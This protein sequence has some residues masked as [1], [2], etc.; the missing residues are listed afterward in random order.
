MTQ[1]DNA[2][3]GKHG[4]DRSNRAHVNLTCE[5]RQDGSTWKMVRLEDL[6]QRGFRIAWYPNCRQQMP[7]KVR[8]PGLEV[9]SAHIRWQAGNSIGCEFDSPL[10]I[11]IFEHI[12]KCA[13]QD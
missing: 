2:T 11:A 8:I 12:A 3:H 1:V 7:L 5:I 9:L 4:R 13:L 10:H 6:S